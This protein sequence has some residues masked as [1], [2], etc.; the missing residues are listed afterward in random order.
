MYCKYTILFLYCQ[1]DYTD[2]YLYLCLNVN[3]LLGVITY[4]TVEV[5]LKKK[6]VLGKT[7]PMIDS[8][9]KIEFENAK[10]SLTGDF[11]I[12]SKSEKKENK[13]VVTSNTIYHLENVI[14]YR[15]TL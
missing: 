4:R 10:T 8:T 14:T 3:I 11:L 15:T 9:E 2:K 5:L 1:L 7:D 12:I 6:K 13:D